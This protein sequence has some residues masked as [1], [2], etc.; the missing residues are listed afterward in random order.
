VSE[1]QKDPEAMA[2]HD[3]EEEDGTRSGPCPFAVQGLTRQGLG[4]KFWKPL[5][6][7]ALKHLTKGKLITSGRT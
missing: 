6:A 3:D 2:A 5:V 1:G 4:N 7:I